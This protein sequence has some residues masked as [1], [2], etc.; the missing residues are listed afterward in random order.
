M[1]EIRLMGI[2]HSA[3]IREASDSGDR[4]Q[5]GRAIDDMLVLSR[6]AGGGA[7][8]M[9]QALMMT[10]RTW[11]A[12][13]LVAEVLHARLPD[14]ALVFV[15]GK[16]RRDPMPPVVALLEVQRH[17]ALEHLGWICEQLRLDTKDAKFY[18]QLGL[19]KS[20]IVHRESAA[21]A[22]NEW[23]DRAIEYSSDDPE[24]RKRGLE[25]YFDIE[26]GLVQRHRTKSALLTRESLPAS[27]FMVERHRMQRCL[28]AGLGVM[29]ALEQY[30][31][32]HGEYP[33]DLEAL[34]PGQLKMIPTDLFA[35]SGPLAYKRIDPATDPFKR[36]YLLYSV[37]LDGI[38]NGG[39]PPSKDRGVVRQKGIDFIIN[40][41]E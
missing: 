14:K 28:E 27:R 2:V 18:R 21:A 32:E 33:A 16:F 20:D 41:P 17:A 11:A 15:E 10:L 26:K 3:R 36:S 7:D 24:V 40:A 29:A 22:C 1:G 31:A 13:R 25:R 23:I 19:G 8:S 6:L 4:G 12:R 37:G 39:A 38:D 35:D 5:I 9:S 34:V 30:R